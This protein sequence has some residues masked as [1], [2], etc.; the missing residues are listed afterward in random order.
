MGRLAIRQRRSV[1]R[2]RL[3]T[4]PKRHCELDPVCNSSHKHTESIIASNLR[5]G[6]RCF[7]H[8]V[9]SLGGVVA[10]EYAPPDVAVQGLLEYNFVGSNWTNTSSSNATAN[11]YLVGAQA[12]YAPGSDQGGFGQAGYIFLVG[13]NDPAS[14]SFDPQS[15]SLVDI[16][17]ITLYDIGAQAWYQQPTTGT[18]PPPRQFFCSVAATSVQATFEM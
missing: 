18:I 13:G 1:I 14:Q 9:Y 8:L 2:I 7:K 16:S 12:A 4:E 6:F 3:H 10:E 15:P 11:G 5:L 17:N